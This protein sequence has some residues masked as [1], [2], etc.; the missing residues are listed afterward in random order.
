MSEIALISVPILKVIKNAQQKH[1]LRQGNYLRYRGYCS[2]KIR[3]LR[4]S[5]DFTNFHKS[6]PK[7]SAKFIR[8]I[9][10]VETLT[11]SRILEIILFE[12]ERNWA[13]S[14]Y[15]TMEF[16][17][18]LHS[19][20]RFH[21]RRKLRRTAKWSL[22][23]EKLVKESELFD[24]ST[25]LEV[26]AYN[27]YMA[28]RLKVEL[29]KWKSALYSFNKAN[30]IYNKFVDKKEEDSN[31]YLSKCREIEDLIRLC[32]FY[33]GE[34]AE[35]PNF[36]DRELLDLDFNKLSVEIK[37]EVNDDVKENIIVKVFEPVPCKPMFFDISMN[38]RTKI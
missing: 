35:L 18:G 38:Y 19:R 4:K 30:K 9:I 2:R 33:C 13:Y 24:V 14:M 8:R 22:N 21:M 1:G 5:S 26:Q 25:K 3:R 7:R 11:N 17:D 37:T 28:G 31:M 6:F 29:K 32:R 16:G 34:I 10:N 15:L 36:S 27:A 23:L 20:K 12:T